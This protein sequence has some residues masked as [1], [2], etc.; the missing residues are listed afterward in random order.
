MDTDQIA[1]NIAKPRSR[2]PASHG[3]WKTGSRLTLERC[4]D[5]YIEIRIDDVLYARV[6]RL[7]LF[8]PTD[9]RA[10]KSS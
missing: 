8:A 10:A 7:S 1:A 5:D 6:A 4:D 3:P 9:P 2:R